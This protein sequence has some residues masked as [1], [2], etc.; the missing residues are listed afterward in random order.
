M[1]NCNCILIEDEPLAIEIIEDYIRQIP[2]L[3][4]KKVCTDALAAMEVIRAETID[5]I[6]LDLHLPKLKGLDFLSTIKNPPKVIITTAYHQYALKS[7]EFNVIDYLLK[8]I[9]FNR[10]LTAVNKVAVNTSDLDVE[11]SKTIFERER[12]HYFFNVGKKKVKLYVDEILYIEGQKEYIKIFT[13]SKMI[14]TKHQIGMIDETLSS[15]NFI[16]IHRS[17]IV[18]KDKIDAYTINDIEIAG[19]VLPIGRSYKEL[20]Q[21]LLAVNK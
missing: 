7:Y 13:E 8:P 1:A 11:K 6:F 12:I 17:F 18:A 16:R 5:L 3:S 21:S 2:F 19:K 15:H 10:F 20:V 14:T 4:L 9:E